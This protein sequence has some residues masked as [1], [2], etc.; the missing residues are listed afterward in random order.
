MICPAWTTATGSQTFPN[1][2]CG[3]FH[4]RIRATSDSTNVPFFSPPALP[5]HDLPPRAVSARLPWETRRAG[6]D[7]NFIHPPP[8]AFNGGR[9]TF[10]K[11]S[12][13]AR[14]S[15]RRRPHVDET[16]VRVGP[17]PLS[18][19]RRGKMKRVEGVP[20]RQWEGVWVGGPSRRAHDCMLEHAS[21]MRISSLGRLRRRA[22]QALAGV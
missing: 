7:F 15:L 19:G 6:G 8:A 5:V 18:H 2:S 10:C 14:R 11:S 3:L 20:G 22:G 13:A 17:I 12:S 4:R 9:D 16:V 1:A 21:V